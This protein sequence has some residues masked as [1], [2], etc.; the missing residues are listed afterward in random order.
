MPKSYSKTQL[1]KPQ[2]GAAFVALLSLQA[3]SAVI[4]EE[5]KTQ[6]GP[7]TVESLAQLDNPWGITLL[8]DGSYLISEKPGNLRIFANGK[9]S[10]PIKGV[11]EVSYRRQGGLLDVEVH[12]DFA[13]N[14]TV[15]ISYTEAAE[16]QPGGKDIA[17]PRLGQYFEAEDNVIKGAA[18]ASA[19][20]DDGALKDVKVI[21][22]QVPKT[23]GRGHFGGRLLF[24]ADGTLFI[25]SGDRQRFDPS[26]D[27]NSNIGKI[28]RINADGSIPKDNPYVGKSG[29]RPDIYSLGHRNPLGAAINPYTQQLW[30]NEMGPMGG[31]E[32]NVVEKA[33]NYGWPQVSEG[34]NYDKTPIPRPSTEP[35][36]A[37]AA[38]SWN[39]SISP[40]GMIFYT[41]D[42]FAAWKGNALV[43]GLSSK[44]LFR[45]TVDGS[46]V[47]GEEKID[48]GKR[49]RD[50]IQD[51]DGTLLLV[52]DASQ[53]GVGGELVRLTPA[54]STMR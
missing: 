17:D 16:K 50:V 30:I 1:R 13:K 5:I 28:L 42:K 21:W 23:M 6:S 34:D 47:T 15:Y 24:A 9:L 37:S 45:L 27:M 46:K 8:P 44:A 29:S 11:P 33:K 14:K 26:Q 53:E 35:K 18:V 3:T 25:T 20:L 43:G 32:V 39:P 54:N 22:R 51:R 31:D 4:A 12:P 7:V 49:I 48:I 2:L 52:I 40:S 38:K 10:E 41:G 19:R 36:L